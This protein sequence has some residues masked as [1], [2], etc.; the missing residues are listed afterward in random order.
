MQALSARWRCSRK[1]RRNNILKSENKFLLLVY[2]ELILHSF[3]SF[4]R[5]VIGK[6][7]NGAYYFD[8]NSTKFG[9]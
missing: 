3:L 8:Q 4:V 9:K 1:E 2:P 6:K 5:N 7:E